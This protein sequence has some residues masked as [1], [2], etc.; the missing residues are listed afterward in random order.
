MSG[1]R[2]YHMAVRINL[3]DKVVVALAEMRF[4]I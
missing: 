3:V 4:L 1:L 2:W